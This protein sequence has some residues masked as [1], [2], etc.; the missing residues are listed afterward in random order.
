[1]L[2]FLF[3]LFEYARLGVPGYVAVI[4]AQRIDYN[5]KRNDKSGQTGFIKVILN[6]VFD[7]IRIYSKFY[8]KQC[9]INRVDTFPSSIVIRHDFIALVESIK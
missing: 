9:S 3:P 5:F 2:L 4:T 7:V 1:M 8:Y 6:C